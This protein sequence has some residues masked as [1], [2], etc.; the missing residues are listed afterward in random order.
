MPE[1]YIFDADGTLRYTTVPG[2]PCPNR[3]DEWRLMPNVADIVQAID[4]GPGGAAMGIASNQNGVG[5][6]Y[7][8]SSAARALLEDTVRAAAG[9]L[10][11][12]LAVEM[13]TCHS[14]VPCGRRK[15]APGMLQSILERF[16][17]TPGHALFVGDLEVDRQAAAA[18][19]VPFAWAGDFFHWNR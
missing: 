8:T 15:P 10:P 4:W 3:S 13:C 1:L 19:S 2:Q 16:Q 17:M 6:G 12:R 5:H 11:A 9:R 18:A 7:L 14:S